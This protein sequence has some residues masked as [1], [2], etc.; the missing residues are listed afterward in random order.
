MS[1]WQE[2]MFPCFMCNS[3][4][5][6]SESLLC[7]KQAF[8]NCKWDARYLSQGI[9]SLGCNNIHLPTMYHCLDHHWEWSTCRKGLPSKYTDWDCHCHTPRLQ[10]D[11]KHQILWQASSNRLV[12]LNSRVWRVLNT[13]L[14]WNIP[15]LWPRII[16]FLLPWT[17]QKSSLK[18]QPNSRLW[19]PL[20][21]HLNSLPQIHMEAYVAGPVTITLWL[22]HP[23]PWET[24][25]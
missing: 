18:F 15:C 8:T 6:L 5:T 25:W 16:P 9:Q 10:I 7:L 19:V 3:P 12:T 23:L 1:S 11:P 4:K 24:S 21:S 2:F 22:H 13:W 20:C 17:V 14:L